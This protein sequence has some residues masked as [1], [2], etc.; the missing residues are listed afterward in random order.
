MIR[1]RVMSGRGRS[2]R[3][4]MERMTEVTRTNSAKVGLT[5]PPGG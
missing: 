5:P 4:T 3:I 1:D 2:G